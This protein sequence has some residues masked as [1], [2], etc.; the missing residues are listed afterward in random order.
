M[1][2]RAPKRN[3]LLS[4][5]A[6]LSTAL[7]MGCSA[8]ASTAEDG[9]VTIRYQNLSGTANLAVVAD[10][11][12]L[13]EGIELERVG[14]A[15]GGPESLQNLATKQVD[16]G[17]AF[18]GAII[19]VASTGVPIT[20]VVTY[21]GASGNVG[22]SLLTPEDG[23][24]RTARDLIGGKVAVGTLGAV[25]EATVHTWLER[26]GLTPEE[27]ASV[28]LVP[29]PGTAIEASLREGRVD[30]ALL[31][32]GGRDEALKRGGLRTLVTD[33]DLFGPYNIGSV[34]LRDEWI[35]DHP[36]Q[37]AELVEAMAEANQYLQNHTVPEARE[38]MIGY[39]TE[40]GRID[41][42]Q[43][44][45]KWNGNGVVT[46]GGVIRA[47]D[48]TL[49]NHWLEASGQIEPGFDPTTIYTNEYNPFTDQVEQ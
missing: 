23:D 43:S 26:E 48:F 46:P 47:Q 37:T 4:T 33:V 10:A 34:A 20:A 9:T 32:R 22:S 45:E 38:L 39:L 44:L 16:M 17:T 30:A 25:A 6:V 1:L 18:N 31:G 11:L 21:S 41:E 28:T 3:F 36:E 19:K 24:I 13:L 35:A 5:A 2:L 40:R 49:W 7:V 15:Q 29:V 27:I 42:A 8:D 12:G 14:E